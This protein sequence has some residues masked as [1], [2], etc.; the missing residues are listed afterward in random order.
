MRR[1]SLVASVAAA[2]LALG[3]VTPAAVAVQSGGSEDPGTID[4]G[5][6]IVEGGES[7]EGPPAVEGESPAEGA[8]EAEEAPATETGTPAEEGEDGDVAA[9]LSL[10]EGAVGALPGV[11]ALL[12]PNAFWPLPTGFATAQPDP[13]FKRGSA[14]YHDPF[15]VAGGFAIPNIDLLAAPL[16]AVLKSQACDN[17]AVTT[18]VSTAVRVAATIRVLPVILT[19]VDG[20]TPDATGLC[21]NYI[22]SLAPSDLLSLVPLDVNITMTNQNDP[23]DVCETT[24]P[25]ES[26]NFILGTGYVF[27][28]K[29]TDFPGGYFNPGTYTIEAELLAD[30]SIGMPSKTV[31]TTVEWTGTRYTGLPPKPVTVTGTDDVSIS[32]PP[33][34]PGFDINYTFTNEPIAKLLN[35][36]TMTVIEAPAVDASWD[37]HVGLRVNDEGYDGVVKGTV[38]FSGS[39]DVYNSYFRTDIQ[40]FRVGNL[41]PVQTARVD[42]NEDF[43]F[44]YKFTDLGV[45]NYYAVPV[46]SSTK[47]LPVPVEGD[48]TRLQVVNIRADFEAPELDCLQ[49]TGVYTLKGSV[50]NNLI[51]PTFVKVTLDGQEGEIGSD[52]V[53]P[54]RTHYEISKDVSAGEYGAT[55]SAWGAKSVTVAGPAVA[56]AKCAELNIEWDPFEATNVCPAMTAGSTLKGTIDQYGEGYAVSVVVTNVETGDVEAEQSEVEI[57]TDVDNPGVGTF[58]IE[59]PELG[60]GAYDAEAVLTYKGEVVEEHLTQLEVEITDCGALVDVE[61]VDPVAKNVC[62]ATTADA[63]L[64]GSVENAREDHDVTYELFIATGDEGELWTPTGDE[65]AVGIEEDGTF[66]VLATGLDAGSYKALVTL[67]AGEE[68]VETTSAYM[69]VE[70][71]DCEKPAP[72]PTPTPKP[73]GDSKPGTL[74][75]TGMIGLPIL[76]LGVAGVTGGYALKRRANKS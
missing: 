54:T 73:G 61:F 74:P 17:V 2:V 49:E 10:D 34:I 40:L 21:Q 76:L 57:A 59:V 47:F 44:S 23:S 30:A 50:H 14:G 60:A 8:E 31:T 22:D 11:D 67:S 7:T 9:V 55:F 18:A 51:A 38:D 16:K 15:V 53:L 70:I 72:T 12:D 24:V 58:A 20:M 33:S 45:G 64:T 32:F 68:V 69:K 65:G 46:V 37:Y 27:A 42:L 48:A 25:F 1:R 62:P 26:G 13:V 66:S 3:V 71:T 35:K 6:G 36:P 56:E 39:L 52:S 29:S 41:L 19:D 75:K 43:G 4:P 5:V 28:A 63:T